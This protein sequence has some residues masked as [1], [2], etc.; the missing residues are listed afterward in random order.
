MDV[1]FVLP[2]SPFIIT[3][4][5]EPTHLSISSNPANNQSSKH[6]GVSKVLWSHQGVTVAKPSQLNGFVDETK[7]R[8]S[9]TPQDGHNIIGEKRFGSD[10]RS[11]SRAR[12]LQPRILST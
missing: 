5:L 11:S 6:L 3:H 10:S 4:I 8:G 7:N 2:L 1:K 12:K 9:S